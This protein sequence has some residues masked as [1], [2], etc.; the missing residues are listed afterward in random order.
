MRTANHTGHDLSIG[1]HISRTTAV[2]VT[3]SDRLL[4]T[5]E[6]VGHAG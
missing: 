4:F 3:R 6:I 2:I 1:P 5:G